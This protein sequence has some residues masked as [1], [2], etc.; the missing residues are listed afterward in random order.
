MYRM[1]IALVLLASGSAA[2]HGDVVEDARMARDLAI[3]SLARLEAVTDP[4]SDPIATGE[5]L[6][7]EVHLPLLSYYAAFDRYED[8]D[9]ADVL[10]FQSCFMVMTVEVDR[11]S[12]EVEYALKSGK[13]LPEMANRAAYERAL[14]ACNT[15]LKAASKP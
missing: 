13:P 4:T 11:F 15:T 9:G 3:S 1:L 12:N 6:R 10:R 14:E 2:A 5:Q 8:Y 7:L